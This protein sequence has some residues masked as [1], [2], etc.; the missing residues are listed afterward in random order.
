[1]TITSAQLQTIKADIAASGDLSI[2]PNTAD[3]NFA[4]AALYNQPAAPAFIVW[5]TSVPTSDCKKAMIWTEFIGRSVGERDAW[6]FMLSN[7]YINAADPNVRQGILDIFSGAQGAQSRVAL[8][9]IAKRGATRL[10]KLLAT[11]T[12]SDASPATMGAEGDISYADIE[13]AR[14]S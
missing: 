3:G 7:G 2:Y 13:A 14:S 9:A 6:Q 11:G 1:M 5:R 12:G 10:E 4:I 8:T